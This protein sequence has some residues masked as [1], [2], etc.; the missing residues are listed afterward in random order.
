MDCEIVFRFNTK[1]CPNAFPK[2]HLPP[3]LQGSNGP[4]N[5]H[6]EDS[7]A[8]QL[9]E[10]GECIFAARCNYAHPGMLSHWL[11]LFELLNELFRF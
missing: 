5:I 3:H 6:S 1:E 7:N 8:Q 10:Y 11:K 4:R 9:N 2:R